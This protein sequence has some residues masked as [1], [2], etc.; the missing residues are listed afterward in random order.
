MHNDVHLVVYCA[1]H[2]VVHSMQ[3]DDHHGVHLGIHAVHYDVGDA[4]Y[5]GQ[6]V[7]LADVECVQL[8]CDP[9]AHSDVDSVQFGGPGVLDVEDVQLFGGPDDQFDAQSVQHAVHN[10]HFAT[11]SGLD[12]HTD[13]LVGIH[14]VLAVH[15]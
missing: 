8:F 1:D 7:Q 9:D 3:F 6:A 11:H 4:Q 14:K 10:V 2:F 15:Y 12:A 5:G 13:L